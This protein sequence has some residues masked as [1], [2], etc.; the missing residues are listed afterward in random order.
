MVDNEK[1]LRLKFQ[2]YSTKEI[3]GIVKL[4]PITVNAKLSGR[5]DRLEGIITEKLNKYHKGHK[6]NHISNIVPLDKDA[7]RV[8]INKTSNCYLTG[9]PLN[10]TDKTS[11]SL[12]HKN[13]RSRGGT[14]SIQNMGVACQIANR[15]KQDMTV[16]E[17]LELCQDVLQNH[18]YI[19]YKK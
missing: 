8:K 15:S 11:W 1:I 9:R 19:V 16:K 5:R 2:G 14:N 12:D 18:G 6:S 13:P 3:A 4:S 17:Y 7:A 10:L